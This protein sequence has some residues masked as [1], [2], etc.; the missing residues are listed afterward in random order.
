MSSKF[1]NLSNTG[2]FYLQILSSV[3]QI[4]FKLGNIAKIDYYYSKNGIT[5][6]IGNNHLEIVVLDWKKNQ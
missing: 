4:P 5:Y 3:L 1:S 6:I 2:I